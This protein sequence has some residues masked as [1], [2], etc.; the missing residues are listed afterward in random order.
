M[1][2]TLPFAAASSSQG[3][4]R[5]DLNDP[6]PGSSIRGGHRDIVMQ[7]ST[8][9]MSSFDDRTPQSIELAMSNGPPPYILAMPMPGGYSLDSPTF[10]GYNVTSFLRDYNRI[11]RRYCTSDTRACELL[12]EYCTEDIGAEVRQLILDA[13]SNF[14][15]L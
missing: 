15:R 4:F 12:K 14:V 5:E 13:R 7:S 6:P 8:D 11:C 2:P 3:E 9:P 10:T 1:D